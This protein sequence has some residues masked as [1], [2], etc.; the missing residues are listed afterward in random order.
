[1]GGCET[2]HSYMA[3]RNTPVHKKFLPI[4]MTSL[5]L[6]FEFLKAHKCE[7]RFP[8]PKETASA[9]QSLA[10]HAFRGCARTC[11][12]SWVNSSIEVVVGAY[13]VPEIRLYRTTPS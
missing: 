4:K 3:A 2:A 12:T 9:E 6:A 5:T 13:P 7:H 11:P 8:S 1:M 10:E